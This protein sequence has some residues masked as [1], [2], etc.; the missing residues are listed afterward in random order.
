MIEKLS[1][2]G[3]YG[4]ILFDGKLLLT[5]KKSGPYKGLWGLPGGMIE[6]NETPEAALKREILEETAH[7]ADQFELFCIAT[8]CGEYQMED[9]TIDFHHIGILYRVGKI[10]I[11]SDQEAEEEMRWGELASLDFDELTPFAREVFSGLI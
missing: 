1:R 7:H 10:D 9:K 6:F 11:V 4:V 2:F 3:S 5:Q 8:S